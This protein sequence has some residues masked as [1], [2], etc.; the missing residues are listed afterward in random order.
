MNRNN[1]LFL[2]LLAVISISVTILIHSL[3]YPVLSKESLPMDIYITDHGPGGVN[4]DKDMIHFGINRP[5]GIS[6]HFL[7]L[8]NH[9]A[10]PTKAILFPDNSLLGSWTSFDTVVHLEP[11]ETKTIRI[12]AQAPD[13]TPPGHYTGRL[14]MELYREKT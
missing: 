7:N 2:I 3:F 8:T 13:K 11:Y 5:L 10:F 9:F 14:N 12:A 6:G 1:I 4:V